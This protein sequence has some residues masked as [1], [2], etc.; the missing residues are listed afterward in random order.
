MNNETL[1]EFINQII[2]D[3]YLSTLQLYFSFGALAIF[4]Y[5]SL[6]NLPDEIKYIWKLK[7]SFPAYLYLFAKY[8]LFV[9]LP[10]SIVIDLAPLTLRY[11]YLITS[12]PITSKTYVFASQC[13]NVAIITQVI[14]LFSF[15]GIQGLVA[16]RTYSLCQGYLPMTI[17]LII[18]FLI[19]LAVQ[20]Y[21]S[22]FSFRGPVTLR[23]ILIHS[24]AVILSDTLAF[25]GIF[26][27]V[28]GLWRLKRSLGLQNNDFLTSLLKQGTLSYCFVLSLTMS[29][30]FLS[31]F[32][33][34]VPT[35]IS[36][37]PIV[38][39]T[40]LICEFTLDLR[41]RNA[42]KSAPNQLAS[43][44][45]PTLSFQEN[46]VQSVRTVL[47]R[48]HESIVAEMGER[49]DP[50]VPAMDNRSPQTA[51]RLPEADYDNMGHPDEDQFEGV[52]N[53][54]DMV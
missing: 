35:V 26:R 49:N 23:I 54:T 17:A 6:L 25:V 38:L 28:W 5:S 47:G 51:L 13:E 29:Q 24:I 50:P 36:S 3:E 21:D 2:H 20:I 34:V 37:L 48:L 40:L 9:F 33:P 41:R 42:K 31:F 43:L 45:L 22:L 15:I 7:F 8:P 53:N 46:P 39:S 52:E 30:I 18:T 1:S 19:A 11:L 16:I 32:A 10:L 27:Q 14:Q 12:N 4:I 44:S